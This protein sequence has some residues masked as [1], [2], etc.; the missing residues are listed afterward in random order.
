M[1]NA[2]LST[3]V[4]TK[5]KELL[6]LGRQSGTSAAFMEQLEVLERDQ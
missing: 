3:I 5:W 2:K 6:N 4:P 1:S